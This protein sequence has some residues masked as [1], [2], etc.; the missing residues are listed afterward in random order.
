MGPADTDTACA[1]CS[2]AESD[3]V[4]LKRCTACK[5]VKYCSRDCQIVHRSQ[6]KKACKKRA[7]ELF[8]EELSK[9]PPERPECPICMLP[10]PFDT[11]QSVFVSCCGTLLCGGCVHANRKQVFGSGKE[12]ETCTFCR[13]PVPKTD[14]EIIDQLKRCVDRNNMTSMDHL[15]AIYRDGV[16]GLQKDPVKAI[17]LFLEAGKLGC[18]DAY[19]RLGNI[20]LDGTWSYWR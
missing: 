7:A 10:L 19:E 17:E 3:D 20:Y 5:M 8:D 11:H 14:T 1:N 12:I 6:H 9:D 16:C 13:A 15:A 4:K 2:K 18:A